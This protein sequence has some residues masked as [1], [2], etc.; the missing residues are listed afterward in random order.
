MPQRKIAPEK[1]ISLSSMKYTI[2]KIPFIGKLFWKIKNRFDKQF[3]GSSSYWVQRYEIGGNSGLGS[4]NELA[5]FKATFSL[6]VP[7]HTLI[8]S[9]AVVAGAS[10]AA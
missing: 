6:N 2:F 10:I 5:L 4:Y 9:P 7:A 3:P 1:F 8:T